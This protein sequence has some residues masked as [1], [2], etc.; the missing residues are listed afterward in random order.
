MRSLEDELRVA[1]LTWSG[2][3]HELWCEDNDTYSSELR[4]T[5]LRDGEIDDILE[6]HIFRD[7]VALVTVADVDKWLREQV[8]A[9]VVVGLS[10][11]Q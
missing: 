10:M 1:G 7:G 5:L 11:N 3:D 4:I 2:P 8:N 9:T 6:F